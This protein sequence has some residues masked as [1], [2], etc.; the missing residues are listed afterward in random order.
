MPSGAQRVADDGRRQDLVLARGVVRALRAGGR[1]AHDDLRT[2][3]VDDDLVALV[4]RLEAAGGQRVAGERLGV[5]LALDERDDVARAPADHGA[6]LD[7]QHE[8]A[9][10]VPFARARAGV[11]LTG[12]DVRAALG[13]VRCR[14]HERVGDRGAV[15]ADACRPR[16]VRERVDGREVRCRRGARVRRRERVGV[17]AVRATDPELQLDGMVAAPALLPG[18][19][20]ASANAWL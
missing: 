12:L 20:C 3:R 16:D 17:R 4:R 5:L 18:H 19:A 10:G 11:G 15:V 9:V 1:A 8:V 2:A 6:R 14:G 7:P 13:R